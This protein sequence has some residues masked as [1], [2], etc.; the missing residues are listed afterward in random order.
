MKIH[1]VLDIYAH[2]R[3]YVEDV[4]DIYATHVLPVLAGGTVDDGEAAR[5]EVILDIHHHQRRARPRHLQQC[6]IYGCC[7][8]VWV[9]FLIH[10]AQQKTNSCLVRPPLALTLKMLRSSSTSADSILDAILFFL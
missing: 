6:E 1:P 3:R 8:I 10:S 2:P 9:A 5:D 7:K 4:V